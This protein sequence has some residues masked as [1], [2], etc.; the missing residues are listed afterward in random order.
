MGRF[1]RAAAASPP[2]TGAAVPRPL[3]CH[4]RCATP[5]PPL[6]EKP[7]A[8]AKQVRYKFTDD[9]CFVNKQSPCECFKYLKASYTSPKILFR[10]SLL[11]FDN[12]SPITMSSRHQ[13][14]LHFLGIPV[15]DSIPLQTLTLTASTFA[16]PPVDFIFE[17]PPATS[18]SLT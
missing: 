1:L 14:H 5:L 16:L 11:K 13:K 12:I 17:G 2:T 3:H 8:T 18:E 7:A 15:F 4:E 6:P 10:Y 9:L